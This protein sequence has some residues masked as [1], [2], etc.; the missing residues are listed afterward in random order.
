MDRDK[1][2]ATRPS[3]RD[4]SD[5]TED[6]VAAIRNGVHRIFCTPGHGITEGPREKIGRTHW[7]EDLAPAL[8][9]ESGEYPCLCL[10]RTLTYNGIRIPPLV[11]D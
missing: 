4:Q 7:H 3:V 8:G 11:E 5:L 9:D 1:N 10:R 2:G 6:F